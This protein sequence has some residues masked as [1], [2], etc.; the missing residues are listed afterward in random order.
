M[1]IIGIAVI[2]MLCFILLILLKINENIIE[3]GNLV[4]KIHKYWDS[5]E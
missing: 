2:V 1:I 3:F 4:N 5:K